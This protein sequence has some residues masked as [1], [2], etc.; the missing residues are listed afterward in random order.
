MKERDICCVNEEYRQW[1][2]SGMFRILCC[3]SVSQCLEKVPDTAM[4]LLHCPPPP[5][6]TLL[7]GANTPCR[8]VIP[9]LNAAFRRSVPPQIMFSITSGFVA[10]NYNQK[11]TLFL[12]SSHVTWYK[13]HHSLAQ[14]EPLPFREI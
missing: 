7:A 2:E 3:H 14:G 9:L 6:R 8:L 11:W 13:H 1:C 5:Q 4:T 10:S 12:Q